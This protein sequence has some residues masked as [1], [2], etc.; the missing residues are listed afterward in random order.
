MHFELIT[1]AL[2]G[3]RGKPR[4]TSHLQAQVHGTA[5]VRTSKDETLADGKKLK[6][7]EGKNK[8]TTTTCRVLRR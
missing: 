8:T 5:I 3:G 4:G 7:Q 2:H 6:K 1:T